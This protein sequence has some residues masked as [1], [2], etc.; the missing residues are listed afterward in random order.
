MATRKLS[1]PMRI[2]NF[3]YKVIM[4]ILAGLSFIFASFTN[5]DKIYYEVVSVFSSA[6]PIIWCQILDAAKQ[7]ETDS[8]P[9]ASSIEEIEAAAP[10]EEPSEENQK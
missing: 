1:K 8:S 5:I 2:A 10:S 9:K 7:Y 6:F 4:A 3:I